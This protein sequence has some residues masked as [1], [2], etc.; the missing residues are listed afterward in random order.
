MQSQQCYRHLLTR[1]LIFENVLIVYVEC[2]DV[3]CRSVFYIGYIGSCILSS[4]YKINKKIKNLNG[5]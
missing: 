5:E 2:T 1:Y 4:L 3:T